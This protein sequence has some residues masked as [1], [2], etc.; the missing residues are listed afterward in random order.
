MAAQYV[1]QGTCT[2]T[3]YTVLENTTK[4]TE[5][6]FWLITYYQCFNYWNWS[7]AVKVPACVQYAHKLAFLVGDTFQKQIHKS[8][9]DK[10]CYL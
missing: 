5:E 4:F 9:V 8:L 10:H 2:P 1:T 6:M 7:G 3:H